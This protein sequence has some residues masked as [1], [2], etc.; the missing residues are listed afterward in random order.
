MGN[1]V[2]FYVYDK[3]S[4]L[5]FLGQQN[6]HF[7]QCWHLIKNIKF[8][9]NLECIFLN[10]SV[11]KSPPFQFHRIFSQQTGKHSIDF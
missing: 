5:Q 4:Y 9:L 11:L 6:K 2:I 1:K 3:I 8:V 10:F 7:L